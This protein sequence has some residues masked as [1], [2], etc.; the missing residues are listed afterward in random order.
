[1][2]GHN[3]TTCKGKSQQV[4]EQDCQ[5]VPKPDSN[6]A[7]NIDVQD[8]FQDVEVE[9]QVPEFVLNEME[10]MSSQPSQPESN[11]IPTVSDF[12]SST[13][14]NDPTP[15]R[16][17]F[18]TVGGINY[19][20][21]QYAV[22]MTWIPFPL[23]YTSKDALARMGPFVN[24]C[25]IKVLPLLLFMLCTFGTSFFRRTSSCP[26]AAA[27]SPASHNN[28]NSSESWG[29]RIQNIEIQVVWRS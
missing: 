22:G 26:H 29:T 7:A 4:Q 11:V 25:F 27:I 1:M 15:S 14:A 9:T 24:L 19:A 17:Q 12:I 6:V 21:V 18:I 3:R 5:G 2:T 20:F 10:S 8:Q 13:I 28:T 23:Q 16:K